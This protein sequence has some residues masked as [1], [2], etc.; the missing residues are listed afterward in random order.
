[1]QHILNKYSTTNMGCFYIF[2]FIVTVCVCVPAHINAYIV[3]VEYKYTACMLRSKTNFVELVK[4]QLCG[5]HSLLP[6]VCGFQGSDQVTNLVVQM[7]FTH[8]AIPQALFVFVV[9]ERV[10]RSPVQLGFHYVAKASLELLILLIPYCL[11][12]EITGLSYH[13][14]EQNVEAVEGPGSQV[15]QEY[16]VPS[17]W[18]LPWGSWWVNNAT[19]HLCPPSFYKSRHN[20]HAMTCALLKLHLLCVGVGACEPRH[21]YRSQRTMWRNCFSLPT[22][23]A[24]RI[25][26]RW[27][28]LVA[29]TLT[30]WVILLAQCYLL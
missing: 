6:P 8:Q 13:A 16:C 25:N 18:T 22:V 20:S 19:L 1:M 29:G 23:W 15:C 2:K 24:V 5:V 21:A 11:S 4:G 14:A 30:Q 12:I 17:I 9:W 26:F 7:L 3:G 28:G 27:S 10:S